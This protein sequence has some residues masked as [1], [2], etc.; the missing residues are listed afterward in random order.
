[1]LTFFLSEGF[2]FAVTPYLYPAALLGVATA[3][4]FGW[5]GLEPDVRTRLVNMI[6]HL[7]VRKGVA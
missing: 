2:D 1:V 6:P 7:F 5:R 3:T 4:L